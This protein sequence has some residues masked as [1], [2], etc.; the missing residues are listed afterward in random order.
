MKNPLESLRKRPLRQRKFIVIAVA[1][2]VG[3]IGL[4]TYPLWGTDLGHFGSPSFVKT[5]ANDLAS[6]ASNI[7]TVTN[8][9][10]D[11]ATQIQNQQKS[12]QEDLGTNEYFT[13]EEQNINDVAVN[14]RKVL[15]DK[16]KTIIWFR[17]SNLTKNT[18]QI[19]P[20]TNLEIVAGGIT[21]LPQPLNDATLAEDYK[22][23]QGQVEIF[24]KSTLPTQS[25]I[26][27]YIAFQ[28]VPSDSAT[29]TVKLHNVLNKDT[30]KKWTYNFI[31]DLEK[32]KTN[33]TA[34]K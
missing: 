14:V 5:V 16:D 11:A 15:I 32:L 4:A 24:D 23:K 25:S 22:T 3:I 30:L 1:V 18:V 28:T 12:F 31:F 27:G 17:I 8:Q 21:Y 13:N 7:A 9:L 20:E 29:F 33:K 19:D 10:Q 2:T 6:T 26:E 34:Q